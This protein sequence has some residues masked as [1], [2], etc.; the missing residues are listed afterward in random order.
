MKLSKF[1]LSAKPKNNKERLVL[2]AVAL[3][4]LGNI[5]TIVAVVALQDRR[6]DYYI[7]DYSLER[8]CNRN[9]KANILDIASESNRAFYSVSNCAGWNYKTG[10]QMGDDIR[11]MM[12]KVE[13]SPTPPEQVRA[14]GYKNNR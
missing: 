1:V 12:K 2:A 13:D 3:S 6:A 5:A 7:A 4:V 9:M 10:E 11:A 14:P 8:M